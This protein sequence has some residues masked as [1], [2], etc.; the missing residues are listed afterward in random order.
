MLQK[1]RGLASCIL[2]IVC[3][4][5]NTALAFSQPTPQGK[6]TILP[7]GFGTP[8]PSALT[9]INDISDQARKAYSK[10]EPRI[11][12]TF[13]MIRS[14][15]ERVKSTLPEMAGSG[16]DNSAALFVQHLSDAAKESKLKED[17]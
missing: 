11:T 9:A 1:I 5:T 17:V 8:L 6:T 13:N 10:T 16:N 4:G 7:A 2:L 3:L 15:W 14:V 12:F